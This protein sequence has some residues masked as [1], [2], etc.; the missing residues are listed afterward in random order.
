MV[1]ILTS[2]R[3]PHKNIIFLSL[4][5]IATMSMITV[6]TSDRSPHKNIISLSLYRITTMIVVL[7]IKTVTMIIVLTK[8]SCFLVFIMIAVLT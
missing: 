3:I 4:Y 1:A 5:R 8:M 7:F 2:D 6:L